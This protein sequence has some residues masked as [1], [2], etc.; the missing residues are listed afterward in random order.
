[1]RS[2]TFYSISVFSASDVRDGADGSKILAYSSSLS[3]SP[4]WCLVELL[5]PLSVLIRLIGSG[6]IPS[7]PSTVSVVVLS[8]GRILLTLL[9]LGLSGLEGGVGMVGRERLR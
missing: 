5:Y 9:Y 2:E 6:A 1:M 8:L 4:S 3:T 7:I